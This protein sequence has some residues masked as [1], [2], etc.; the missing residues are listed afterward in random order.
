MAMYNKELEHIKMQP[1][2]IDSDLM[3]GIRD[4]TRKLEEKE[5]QCLAAAFSA[6]FGDDW[7]N[8]FGEIKYE[9]IDQR[10]ENSAYMRNWYF[11]GELFL[12]TRTWFSYDTKEDGMQSMTLHADFATPEND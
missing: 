9:M 2:I 6:H 10:F 3:A 5:K 7:M 1:S 11:R 4:F 8:H 12:I